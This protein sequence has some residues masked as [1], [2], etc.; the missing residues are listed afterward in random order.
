MVIHSGWH[1][2]SLWKLALVWGIIGQMKEK[3]D[4]RKLWKD[5]PEDLRD[6]LMSAMEESSA[7]TPE[8]FL[9]KYS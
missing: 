3:D 6:E 9:M 2:L 4:F 8:E 1:R 7:E 5:L